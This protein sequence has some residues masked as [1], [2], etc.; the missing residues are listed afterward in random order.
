[1]PPLMG[2]RADMESAPTL[3][4]FG[5]SNGHHD[6]AVRLLSLRDRRDAGKTESGKG[7]IQA[8]EKPAD[9]GFSRRL[10]I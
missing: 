2:K 1:M 3:Y 6:L 10:S 5:N 8:C 7:L 9:V 4:L